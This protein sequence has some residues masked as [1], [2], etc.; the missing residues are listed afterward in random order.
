[1]K[2]AIAMLVVVSAVSASATPARAQEQ[3]QVPAPS[4]EQRS[5]ELS[6]WLKEYREW[7]QWFAL[8]G[9]RVARNGN[10]FQVWERKERPQPPAWL[11]DVCRDELVVDDQLASAC[12]I[13]RTW[14]DQPAQII[15]RR[16]SPVGTSGGKSADTVVKSSFFQRVHLTGLWARAQYPGTPVYGIVG[17]QIAVFETGRFTLPATGVMMVMIPDGEGGYDWRPATTVGFGYR[18]FDF[19]PPVHKKPVSLHLNVARSHIH[20]LQDE[21]IISGSANISFVG[22]SVSGRRRR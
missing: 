7:E 3:A 18:L 1:M 16:G 22:F 8:W 14:D 10:D 17:M 20:G 11:A 9:N 12:H 13:L 2:L 6:K 19:V 15:Q 4:L 21:R 5:D